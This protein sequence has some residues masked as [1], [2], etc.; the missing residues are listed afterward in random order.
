MKSLDRI[1]DFAAPYLSGSAFA[2]GLVA[3]VHGS[4]DVAGMLIASALV[5]WSF[6]ICHFLREQRK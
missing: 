3:G 6:L 5:Y 4:Y 1:N 2:G